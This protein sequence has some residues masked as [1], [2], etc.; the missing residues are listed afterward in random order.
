MKRGDTIP[1]S[2]MI[3]EF[4]GCC[5]EPMRVFELKGKPC[6]SDCSP[7]NHKRGTS[8]HRAAGQKAKIGE[9]S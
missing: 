5:G 9:T 3:R 1:G 8:M 4:C 2:R 7:A 6:C